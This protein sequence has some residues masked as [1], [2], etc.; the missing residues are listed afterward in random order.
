MHHK[1]CLSIPHSV[2]TCI[3]YL[4]R[5]K[6]VPGSNPVR[7]AVMLTGLWNAWCV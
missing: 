5:D 7:G 6:K 2:A 3:V 4:T 1:K